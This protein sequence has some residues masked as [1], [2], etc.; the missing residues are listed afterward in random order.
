MC[1][2]PRGVVVCLRLTHTA[3]TSGAHVI[4]HRVVGDP[5]HQLAEVSCQWRDTTRA[6][7]R[8]RSTVRSCTHDSLLKRH[9]ARPP[10]EFMH[11]LWIRNQGECDF[12]P[13]ATLIHRVANARYQPHELLLIV[14]RG[15]TKVIDEL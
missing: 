5:G 15:P 11:S 10:G 3:G 7:H 12:E 13:A 1:F 4:A 14:N 6:H 2:L 9:K 8:R